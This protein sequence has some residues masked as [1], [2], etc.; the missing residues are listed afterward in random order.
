MLRLDDLTAR[1]TE[2]TRRHDAGNQLAW[3]SS[4]GHRRGPAW[5]IRTVLVTTFAR[6]TRTPATRAGHAA[7]ITRSAI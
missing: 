3:M 2:L 4:G 6:F 7:P 5:G 1:T